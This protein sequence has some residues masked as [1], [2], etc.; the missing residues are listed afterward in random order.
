MRC[1]NDDF[2]GFFTAFFVTIYA[3][4]SSLLPA[5]KTAKHWLKTDNQLQIQATAKN[6]LDAFSQCGFD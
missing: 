4:P 5:Q 1:P 3:P 2:S 6:I